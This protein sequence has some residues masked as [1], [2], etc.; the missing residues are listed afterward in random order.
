MTKLD[1]DLLTFLERLEPFFPSPSHDRKNAPV[2]T[3]IM[4]QVIEL[5]RRLM[6]ERTDSCELSGQVSE[7]VRAL[8][9]HQDKPF[10]RMMR[11]GRAKT[12]SQRYMRAITVPSGILFRAGELLASVRMETDT[13]AEAP[14]D[15]SST[16]CADAPAEN[17]FKVGDVVQLKSGGVAMTVAELDCFSAECVFMDRWGELKTKDLPWQCLWRPGQRLA[18]RNDDDLPF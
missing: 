14:A 17:P 2:S 15:T 3:G 9:K 4:A 18:T 8:I 10:I 16:T 13:A 7:I 6:A 11:P 12:D 5:N 1:E